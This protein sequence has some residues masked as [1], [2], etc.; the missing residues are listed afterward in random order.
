MYSKNYEVNDEHIDFQGVVDGL[1]FPFYM[2]WC[3]HSFMEEQ[4]GV[5]L[6]EEAKRG[7]M[8]V[9]TEYNIKFKKPLK[10][11]DNLHVTCELKKGE[12]SSR[13]NF[14][15]KILVNDKIH[16]EATFS[17]TCVTNGKPHVP[18]KVKKLI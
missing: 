14:I 10:K 13:F 9:L 7:N 11:E 17:A 15:Q 8:Y 16:A 2:E 18:E 3:R 6:E 1:Y 4:V 5:N 12:R